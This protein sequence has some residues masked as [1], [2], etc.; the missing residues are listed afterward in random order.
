LDGEDDSL[1]EITE[2]DDSEGD[3]AEDD[4]CE[5]SLSVIPTLD[6]VEEEIKLIKKDLRNLSDSGFI[7][8]SEEINEEEKTDSVDDNLEKIVEEEELQ[9]DE[10]NNKLV[11]NLGTLT[12]DTFI[13]I[14]LNIMYF[15]YNL[16]SSELARISCANHKVN[17]CIRTALAKHKPI[18]S[19]IRSLNAYVARIK[20]TIELNKVFANAKCRLR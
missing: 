1:W 3:E 11:I 17:L 19:N 2:E 7:K 9:A 14:R 5:D 18:N 20:R 8:T 16:G 10:I 15:F 6:N 4:D 13:G 12:L